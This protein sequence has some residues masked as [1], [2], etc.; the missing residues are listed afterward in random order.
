MNENLEL[1][2][3]DG[4]SA[5]PA[6]PQNVS[7][8]PMALLSL[9]VQKG[10]DVG[11]LERL[12]VL[13]DKFLAEQARNAFF[14]DLAAF[15][16]ELPPIIRV[17]DGHESRYRYAPLE[18]IVKVATPYL[19]KYGFSHQEDGIVTDG[20]VEA[21]VTVTHR[22]GHKEEKRFKVPS[23]TKAGMSPQQKYGAAMTYAT[24]YAFC[25]A[26][27]IRTAD[28]DTDCPPEGIS[29]TDARAKLWNLLLPISHGD[30]TWKTAQQ[31]LIDE[32]LLEPHQKIG[33]LTAPEIVFLIEKAKGKLQ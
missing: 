30:G 2:K 20:W 21:V 19:N 27:G 15:Q 9:A 26:F 23:E 14:A 28:K 17:K 11:T 22:L 18:H 1:L 6:T 33:G 10:A 29:V 16:A 25:A 31:W 24:R 3:P 8:D 7:N 32:C 13:R 12:A 4:S 5:L